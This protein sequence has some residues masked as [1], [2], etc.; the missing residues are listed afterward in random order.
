MPYVVVSLAGAHLAT[1]NTDTN[2]VVSVAVAGDVVGPNAATINAIAGLYGEAEE[3]RHQ[4]YLDQYTL[5]SGD[6][7]V[8]TFASH[9]ERQS[10]GRTIE[11]LHP[12]PKPMK[13]NWTTEE[14]LFEDFRSRI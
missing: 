7:F 4:I 9:A 5:P 6:E 2:Y 14:E 11:E 1:L 12:N 8:V 3:D 13:G 10:V